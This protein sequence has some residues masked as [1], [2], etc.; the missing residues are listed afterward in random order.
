MTLL[1]LMSLLTPVSL[2]VPVLLVAG[3]AE[4]SMLLPDGARVPPLSV[5]LGAIV[6]S[7]VVVVV[8]SAPGVTVVVLSVVE[9]VV[10]SLAAMLGLV[11]VPTELPEGE[12][13]SPPVACA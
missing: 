7:G 12:L 6:L 3:S 2:D 10:A 8:V 4:L 5:V 13:P 1:L 9:P 11:V